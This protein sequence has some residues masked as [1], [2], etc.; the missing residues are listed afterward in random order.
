[1]RKEARRPSVGVDVAIHRK[2]DVDLV[3]RTLEQ[4]AVLDARP[5]E[6]GGIR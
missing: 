5:A 3:S 6:P 1:M 2:K 4:L